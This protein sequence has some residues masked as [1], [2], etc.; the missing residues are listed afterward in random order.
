MRDGGK[1]EG[2]IPYGN[3]ERAADVVPAQAES[4]EF[5]ELK[6]SQPFANAVVVKSHG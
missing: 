1:P 3:L 4:E 6:G 5:T 2:L